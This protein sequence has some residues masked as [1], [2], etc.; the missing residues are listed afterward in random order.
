MAQDLTPFERHMKNII[1][2]EKQQHAEKVLKEILEEIKERN[3]KE[4]KEKIQALEM[5]LKKIRTEGR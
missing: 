5:Q 2:K 3:E 4:K 1:K